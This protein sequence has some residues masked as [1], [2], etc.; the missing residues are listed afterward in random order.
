MT[1][2]H[3]GAE[4]D[5]EPQAWPKRAW[6]RFRVGS[7]LDLPDATAVPRIRRMG[8]ESVPRLV[9]KIAKGGLESAKA[10][11]LLGRLAEWRH[12]DCITAIEPLE[13]LVKSCD[14]VEAQS[15]AM[16]LI[17]INTEDSIL[18]ALGGYVDGSLTSRKC[19]V[20]AFT[21]NGNEWARTYLEAAA[22]DCKDANV[23]VAAR[24]ILSKLR[25]GH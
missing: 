17:A 11:H 3:K 12:I 14:F 22:V 19:V 4:R 18:A 7:C 15:A 2:I 6:N 5:A 1:T 21:A 16:A 9:E 13:R 10:A 20:S 23:R 24:R 8:Q 25:E